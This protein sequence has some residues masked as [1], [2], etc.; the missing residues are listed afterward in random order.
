MKFSTLH[1]RHSHIMTSDLGTSLH[2]LEY[3]SWEDFTGCKKTGLFVS[4]LTC[5]CFDADG[6]LFVRSLGRTYS[7]CA[8]VTCFENRTKTSFRNALMS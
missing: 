7:V 4:F 3:R 5:D 2:R 8:E 1:V 6:L